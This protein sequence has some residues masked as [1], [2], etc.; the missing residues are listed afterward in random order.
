[1]KMNCLN[2]PG[3]GPASKALTLTVSSYLCAASEGGNTSAGHRMPA[4]S[5]QSLRLPLFKVQG[6]ESD[7]QEQKSSGADS[8]HSPIIVPTT[9]VLPEGEPYHQSPANQ[10]SSSITA[11]T[12][13]GS[14]RAVSPITHSTHGGSRKA[15]TKG[16]SKGRQRQI[17][18]LLLLS[19]QRLCYI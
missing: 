10:A 8:T 14:T 4:A 3:Q 11:S 9:T 18:E 15:Q 12:H 16:R 5:H 2:H 19:N 13:P 6:R 1:M 17:E 7:F